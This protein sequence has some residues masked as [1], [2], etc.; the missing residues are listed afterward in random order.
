MVT[1]T[2]FKMGVIA[3]ALGLIEGLL[4]SFLKE[5]PTIEVLG[6]QGAV[7]GYFFTVKTISDI[8][9]VSNGKNGD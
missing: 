7:L 4:K 5:F 9:E 8:K 2:R 3:L 1:Q 6:F